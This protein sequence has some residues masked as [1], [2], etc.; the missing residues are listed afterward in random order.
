MKLILI[1][2][3]TNEISS[4]TMVFVSPHILP[5]YCGLFLFSVFPHC[6]CTPL[7]TAVLLPIPSHHLFSLTARLSLA[8]FTTPLL[9]LLTSSYFS[10]L[11]FFQSTFISLSVPWREREY[12]I[13]TQLQV[14]AKQMLFSISSL[15]MHGQHW[16]P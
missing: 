7:F 8:P 12:S 9:T 14:S 1:H 4:I 16:K 5:L 13:A 6:I 3:H 10:P 2:F 15:C 11:G